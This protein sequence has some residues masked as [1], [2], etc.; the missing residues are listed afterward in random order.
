[1]L[2]GGGT[3]RERDFTSHLNKI[4]PKEKEAS[5]RCG[6]LFFIIII[7]LGFWNCFLGLES[8]SRIFIV[9]YGAL[10]T[11]LSSRSTADFKPPSIWK[12][13][14]LSRRISFLPKSAAVAETPQV[15]ELRLRWHRP[16]GLGE[17]AR[18]PGWAWHPLP[19]SFLRPLPTA[20]S[21][22][23]LR[24]PHRAPPGF[25]KEPL[26]T[27]GPR[28]GHHSPRWA[29]PVTNY[30]PDKRITIR[31]ERALRWGGPGWGGGPLPQEQRDKG[32]GTERLAAQPAARPT[33]ASHTGFTGLPRRREKLAT[34]H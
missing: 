13:S 17:G 32:A 16:R 28:S 5:G 2:G 34:S 7:F 33:A 1:M 25:F 11:R 19:S 15:P 10:V 6:F 12:E 23:P 4:L 29:Q 8:V 20:T 18:R 27:P 14:V 9:L 30:S 3:G 22:P 31:Q 21:P 26:G 24:H